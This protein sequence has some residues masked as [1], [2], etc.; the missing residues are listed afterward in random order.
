MVK[1]GDA[2]DKL[3]DEIVPFLEPGDVIMDGGNSHFQDTERRIRDLQG[4]GIF[5]LGVGVSGG[6]K[7]ALL[8]PSIMPGGDRVGWGQVSSILESIA[9]RSAD[10]RP[11]TDYMGAGGAGHFVKMVHNGIEYAVMQ[12]IAETYDLLVR[13]HGYPDEQ[14]AK[15]FRTWNRGPGS[16]YLLEITSHILGTIDPSSGQPILGS[17]VDAAGSKGTGLWTTQTSLALGVPAPTITAAVEA[18]LISGLRAERLHAGALPGV[19]TNPEALSDGG[20]SLGQAL[21]TA[22]LMAYAQGFALLQAA[23]AAWSWGLDPVRIARVWREGCIIRA[24][25]L[26]TLAEALSHPGLPN[27]LQA[28][29]MR[30]TF[31]RG[32][33]HLRQAVALAARQGVPAPALASSLAYYDAYRSARLPANLIQAQRDYFGYHGFE[34]LDSPG[35]FHGPWNNERQ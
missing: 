24:A 28:A 5:F 21:L 32:G 23:E 4:A 17:I 31:S 34:R 26:D 18:R 12:L 16:S 1:A 9:A 25:F 29:T 20:D 22:T 10:G 6:E 8:G 35:T 3:I 2:V 11:C 15:I 33:S 27:L 13:G 30:E 7:G 14:A 19:L